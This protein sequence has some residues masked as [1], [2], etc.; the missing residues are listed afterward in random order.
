MKRRI[1]INDIAT[2]SSK[3]IKRK[4]NLSVN[5]LN[6][7]QKHQIT[8]KN[9]FLSRFLSMSHNTLIIMN[10]FIKVVKLNKK[11]YVIKTVSESMNIN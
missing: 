10:I 6:D 3:R 1:D 4:S 7:D 9:T 11:I 2:E 8:E 5:E